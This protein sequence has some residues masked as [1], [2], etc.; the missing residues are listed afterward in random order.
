MATVWETMG[1]ES[2][3]GIDALKSGL[4]IEH[5]DGFLS[6]TNL[7]ADAV[8]GILGTSRADVALRGHLSPSESERLWRV[9]TIYNST[10]SLFDGDA[11]K[12]V[13]WLQTPLPA[14]GEVSPLTHAESEPGAG[15]V[16]ALI[17]QIEHGVAA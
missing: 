5:V 12:T 1:V 2:Q 17:W 13:A 11:D 8:Y 3:N 4:P 6:R 14:F 15:E 10:L 9:A 7:P 16:Q